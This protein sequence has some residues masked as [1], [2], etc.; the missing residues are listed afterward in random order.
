LDWSYLETW[1]PNWDYKTYKSQ[2]TGWR[3][4]HAVSKE[5][6]VARSK[7]LRKNKMNTRWHIVKNQQKTEE[8]WHWIVRQIKQLIILQQTYEM[9]DC[10]N[11]WFHAGGRPTNAP[12]TNPTCKLWWKSVGPDITLISSLQTGVIFIFPRRF[13]NKFDRRLITGIL[14]QSSSAVGSCYLHSSKTLLYNKQLPKSA[15]HRRRHR[16]SWRIL[17]Y[18]SNDC[19]RYVSNIVSLAVRESLH[20]GLRSPSSLYKIM[21]SR[22]KLSVAGPVIYTV[23]L[24]KRG[25]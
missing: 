1:W 17:Q 3:R 7:H 8:R 2:A 22:T 5:G 19:L 10:C 18:A 12:S 9:L 14:L 24:K 25:Q 6:Y 20:S 15:N 21:R 23:S 13:W 16:H 11:H 4:L